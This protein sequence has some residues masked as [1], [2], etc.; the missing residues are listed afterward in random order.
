[1]L[2][3]SMSEQHSRVGAPT[4]QLIGMVVLVAR[5]VVDFLA[6]GVELVISGTRAYVKNMRTLEKIIV[7]VVCRTYAPRIVRNEWIGRSCMMALKQMDVS[8][9]CAAFIPR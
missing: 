7:R 6:N 4:G 8:W 5:L 9:T 2:T 3:V 1:M